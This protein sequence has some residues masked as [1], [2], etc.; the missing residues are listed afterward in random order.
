[1]ARGCLLRRRVARQTG[2]G[3]T[4]CLLQVVLKKIIANATMGNDM[5]PLF[6]DVVGCMGI[7]V[8]E[9]KKMVCESPGAPSCGDSAPCPRRRRITR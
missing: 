8:L 9:I 6:A 7:Q 3:L 1:M 4:L 2:A 5:G